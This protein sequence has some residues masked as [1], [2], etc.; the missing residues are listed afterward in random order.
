[1]FV[2]MEVVC[3]DYFFFN[4]FKYSILCCFAAFAF[5]LDPNAGGQTLT[6]DI[7]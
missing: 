7:C 2:I 1:M 6:H 5:H 4:A 3:F